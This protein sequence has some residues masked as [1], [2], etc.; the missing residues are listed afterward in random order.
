M[1]HTRTQPA[2]RLWEPGLRLELTHGAAQ[3]VFAVLNQP[4]IPI[5]AE[6]ARET[7]REYCLDHQHGGESS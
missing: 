2:K 1:Q 4:D 7:L 6:G 3:A 5:L